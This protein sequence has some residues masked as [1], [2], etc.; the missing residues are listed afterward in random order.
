[1]WNI[2]RMKIAMVRLVPSAEIVSPLSF[3]LP[4]LS[5]E[6]HPL[7]ATSAKNCI[8]HAKG[9]IQKVYSTLASFVITLESLPA[10]YNVQRNS[11]SDNLNPWI[12]I[13]FTYIYYKIS[14][15]AQLVKNLPAMQKTWIDPW[16]GR[17]LEKGMATHSSI[18]ASR[19]P[20]REK[21]GSY[22]PWGCKELDITERLTLMH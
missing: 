10:S 18:L 2:L 3:L 21:L 9:S 4:S 6:A 22:S 12:K 19:I 1:M 16:V 14:L 20:Y 17:P 7:I 15:V 11:S 8:H 5:D 13:I